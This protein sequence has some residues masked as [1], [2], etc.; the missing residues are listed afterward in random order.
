MIIKLAYFD[1]KF[2]LDD[3]VVPIS[4]K[5]VVKYFKGTIIRSIRTIVL[6]IDHYCTTTY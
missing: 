4:V 3:V 2:I 6:N 5:L 1:R